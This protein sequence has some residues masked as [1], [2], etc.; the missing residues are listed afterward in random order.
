MKKVLLITPNIP[1]A[2]ILSGIKIR[3]S[4]DMLNAGKK[5]IKL[6]AKNVLIKGG[7]LKSK[8]VQDIFVNKSEIKIFKS[9]RFKTMNT[10]G[11]GCTLS[12][13]ITTFLS[14]GKPLKKSCEL[15][16]KYVGSAILTNPNYGYG[17]GPINHLNSMSIKKKFK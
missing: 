3:S 17:H 1:E 9:K 5:L 15:G 14:C 11:T 12:S 13:A 10:H 7:H 8:L 16:I 4:K 6:G 2:E